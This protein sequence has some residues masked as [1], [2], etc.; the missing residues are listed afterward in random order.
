MRSLLSMCGC[1]LLYSFLIG[2][3][4]ASIMG[5][6]CDWTGSGL[7]TVQSD[8]GVTPVYLRC[9]AGKIKW[10][11]PRGALRILLRL[12]NQNKNFRTCLKIRSTSK[13]G[14][15]IARVYL[16]GPRSLISLFQGHENIN[17]I[18]CFNSKN[19]QAAIYMEA[20]DE[21]SFDRQHTEIEYDLQPI[22][23]SV[24][25]Y[26]PNEECRPCS[27]EEMAHIFCT[28]DLVARGT[29]NSVENNDVIEQTLITFQVTKL[30]R[31][32]PSTED[33]LR[34]T[35]HN[36]IESSQPH[37]QITVIVPQHC[38]INHGLGEF[39]FMAKRKLGD[40]RLLCAPRLETWSVLVNKLNEEGKSY[41]VLRS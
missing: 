6:E 35:E 12:P 37:K 1:F 31:H 19:G 23:W 40:M 25:G 10:L 14:R 22:P 3:S 28:S 4:L 17:L 5:D 7:S 30:I 13:P 2:L 21:R 38:G 36:E 8:K 32:I 9:A 18:K 33:F 26:D 29:I 34:E 27:M 15:P 16:E 24:Y 41:C 11:Y 20:T 39:V